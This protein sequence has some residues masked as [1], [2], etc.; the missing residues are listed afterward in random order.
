MDWFRMQQRAVQLYDVNHARAA[1]EAYREHQLGL[2]DWRITTEGVAVLQPIADW[3][4]HMQGTKSYPTLPLVLP[5]VYGLI[6][7]MGPTEPLTLSFTGEDSYELEPSEMQAGVLSARTDMH[8]DWVRRW[9]TNIDPH[10]K[11]IYAIATMLHPAF[12][13][14]DFIDDFDLI[15]QTDKAWALSELRNEWLTVWKPRPSDPSTSS[16]DDSGAS[17]SVAAAAPESEVSLRPTQPRSAR[18]RCWAPCSARE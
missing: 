6:E 17:T 8:T 2:E 1:G 3:T 14:Y 5:T 9:I 13:Q 18:S 4:Q 7:G 16:A 10:A 11:R 12:K 15:P